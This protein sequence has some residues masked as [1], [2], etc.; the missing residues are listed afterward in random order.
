MPTTV[1]DPKFATLKSWLAQPL[2]SEIKVA[3]TSESEKPTEPAKTTEHSPPPTGAHASE[4]SSDLKETVP[5]HS[6]ESGAANSDAGKVPG[7]TIDG[8]LKSGPS[9]WKPPMSVTTVHSG[10][11]EAAALDLTTDVGLEAAVAK[12]A[13][14]TAD[15]KTVLAPT[16]A[17]PSAEPVAPAAKS[18][19]KSAA[20]KAAEDR[21]RK[22]VED[23]ARFGHTRG[24]VTAAY[25]NA[26]NQTGEYLKRAEADGTLLQAMGMG[27]GGPAG[28][29]AGGMP[30]APGGDMP[31]GPA[32]AGGPEG[33]PA[34]GDGMTPDDMAGGMGEMGITPEMLEQLIALLQQKGQEKGQAPEASPAEKEAFDRDFPLHKKMAGDTVTHIRSG[35]FRFK[36]AGDGT[37]E[38]SRRD[39]AKA[40][41]NEL[42]DF[43]TR[44]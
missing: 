19:E 37:A 40:Y 33:P 27:P 39:K 18:T 35:K 9:D 32:G 6:V 25:I 14:L 43:S 15:L 41:L 4:L 11:K 36:P 17:R 16:G 44:N 38:R 13:S 42:R 31:P 29:G 10:A 30:P 28:G 3:S 5:A 1:T 23:Y 20:E 12:L 2:A 8:G 26:F 22:V 7:T 21:A 24:A 34:G